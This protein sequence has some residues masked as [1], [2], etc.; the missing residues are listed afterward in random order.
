LLY[1]QRV[2]N[3]VHTLTPSFATFAASTYRSGIALAARSSGGSVQWMDT[4]VLEPF[5]TILHCLE[6]LR[7]MPLPARDLAGDTQRQP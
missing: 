2:V 6:L 1:V 4:L 3:S 5:E 7:G